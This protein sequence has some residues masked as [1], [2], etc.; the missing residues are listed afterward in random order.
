MFFLLGGDERKRRNI[1]G[2]SRFYPFGGKPPKA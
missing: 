1:M 2:V